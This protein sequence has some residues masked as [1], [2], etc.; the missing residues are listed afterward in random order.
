MALRRKRI[1]PGSPELFWNAL[2][3][4]PIDIEPP[5]AKKVLALSELHG[6][7]VYDGAYLDLAK[8]KEWPLATLDIALLKA[9]SS[10]GIALVEQM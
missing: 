7:T 3:K 6:L 9:A 4:L 1:Q 5:Q 2:A 8:R 10:E